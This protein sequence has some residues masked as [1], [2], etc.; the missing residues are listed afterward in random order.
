MPVCERG[1]RDRR[2]DVVER[3]EAARLAE[4]PIRDGN[5]F[6]HV[7]PEH[8]GIGVA[9]RA[10]AN[11]DAKFLPIAIDARAPVRRV[12]QVAVLRVPRLVALE[13]QDVVASGGQL[14]DESAVGRRV[15]VAPRRRDRQPEEHD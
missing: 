10:A 3:R 5:P 2:V 8:D 13:E 6:R 4:Q 14:A 11:R 12:R 15:A 7:R 1:Q 9:D